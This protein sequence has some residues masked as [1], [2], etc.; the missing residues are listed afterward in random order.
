MWLGPA[1]FVGVSILLW[2]YVGAVF[3]PEL[4]AR[5]VFRVLPVLVEMEAVIIVN[6]ALIYFAAY[7]MFAVSWGRLRPYLGT[8]FVA[9]LVLWLVNVLVL[10][11]VLGRGVMGYQLPQG[12]ISASF[13]LIVSHWTFAR[14][15]QFQDKR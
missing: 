15:L 2:R 4:M 11:P 13:P 1:L 12:W 6:A 3:M 9:A 14:G 8:P 10:L 5:S 7:F